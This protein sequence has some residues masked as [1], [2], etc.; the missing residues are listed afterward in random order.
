MEVFILK[1]RSNYPHTPHLGVKCTVPSTDYL[2][3]LHKQI[4]WKVGSSYSYLC[5]PETSIAISLL[6]V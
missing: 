3:Y 4:L 6:T 2:G 5:M 1:C